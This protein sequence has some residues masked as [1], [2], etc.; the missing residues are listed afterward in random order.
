MRIRV[1]PDVLRTLSSQLHN[2]AE[3]IQHLTSELERA[4]QSMSWE[5]S[6]RE[7]LLRQWQQARRLSEHIHSSL[8]TMGTQLNTKADQ[9]QTADHQYSTILSFAHSSQARPAMMFRQSF[10]GTSALLTEQGERMMNISDPSS[11][12]T[13]IRGAEY[14][15][16][17]LHGDILR[18][19]S[20]EQPSDWHFSDPAFI[21]NEHATAQS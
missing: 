9:F 10:S 20:L 8:R 3:Q 4:L 17:D 19:A 7:D 5:S 18:Q 11:V 1:E 12:M 13:V 14:R 16:A 21:R 6:A 15:A 2:A